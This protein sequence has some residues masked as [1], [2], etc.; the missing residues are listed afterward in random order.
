LILPLYLSKSIDTKPITWHQIGWTVCWDPGILGVNTYTCLYISRDDGKKLTVYL[1]VAR[2]TTDVGFGQEY[3]Y[4]GYSHT[5]D[6]WEALIDFDN[7]ARNTNG[8]LAVELL[9][10]RVLVL[11]DDIYK[12]DYRGNQKGVQLTFVIR[13]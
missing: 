7:L 5:Q 10:H 12:P 4:R 3:F 1:G 6:G 11:C 8:G 2:E 9:D 13:L